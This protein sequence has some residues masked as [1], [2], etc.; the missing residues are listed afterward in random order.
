M[1][2]GGHIFF[3]NPFSSLLMPPITVFL[4]ISRQA[5]LSGI[6][7]GR[8]CGGTEALKTLMYEN[9]S[10]TYQSA[11]LLKLVAMLSEILGGGLPKMVTCISTITQLK[12]SYMKS[13]AL[14]SQSFEW[15]TWIGL[16]LDGAQL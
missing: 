9:S 15:Y 1:G 6:N 2:K 4:A 11:T 14:S 8:E 10:S 3:E 16:T 13:A 12:I 7:N 5:I